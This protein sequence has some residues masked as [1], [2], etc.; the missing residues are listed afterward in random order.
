[1]GGGHGGGGKSSTLLD[2]ARN[3]VHMVARTQSQ[4]EPAEVLKQSAADARPA[5]P[6]TVSP[7]G[8]KTS[9]SPSARPK[10]KVSWLPEV[11]ASISSCSS[12]GIRLMGNLPAMAAQLSPPRRPAGLTTSSSKCERILFFDLRVF[13]K[14]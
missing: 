5:E 7:V 10:W 12:P 3:N 11:P 9:E 2:A 8:S 6:R 1:V 4:A 14:E 13:I